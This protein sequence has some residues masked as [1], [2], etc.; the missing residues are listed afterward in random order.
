MKE[1][2]INIGEVFVSREDMNFF[3]GA[4]GAGVYAVVKAILKKRLKDNVEACLNTGISE[5]GLYIA[6]GEVKALRTVIRDLELVASPQGE[7]EVKEEEEV[8]EDFE[9]IISEVS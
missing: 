3:H 2:G 6:Q 7:E 5:R 1:N 4:E 8:E 9:R